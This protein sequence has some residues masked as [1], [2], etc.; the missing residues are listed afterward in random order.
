MGYTK[1]IPK[2]FEKSAKFPPKKH[3]K[4]LIFDAYN[5][6]SIQGYFYNILQVDKGYSQSNYKFS[7]Q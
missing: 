1:K 2:K 6:W 7:Y 5:K 3:Q 4:S